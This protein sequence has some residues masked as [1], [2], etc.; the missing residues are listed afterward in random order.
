MRNKLLT[1]LTAVIIGILCVS[2]AFVNTTVR[3]DDV[4]RKK[5][6][7]AET[8]CDSLFR[9]YS[10]VAY[11][12]CLLHSDPKGDQHLYIVS[13]YSLH[14][15]DVLLSTTLDTVALPYTIYKQSK[16]GSIPLEKEI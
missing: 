14:A 10:S 7:E 13:E 3:G 15:L 1:A 9:V 12:G 2:C 16:Y 11:Y 6:H 4:V 5:L 8:H